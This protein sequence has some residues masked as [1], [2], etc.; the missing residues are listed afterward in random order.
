MKM[1]LGACSHL[2]GHHRGTWSTLEHVF[3]AMLSCL[4]VWSDTGQPWWRSGTLAQG[5]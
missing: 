1:A 5:S 4:L 2:Q 3:A